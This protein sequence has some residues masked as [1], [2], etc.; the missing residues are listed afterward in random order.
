M[1]AAPALTLDGIETSVDRSQFGLFVLDVVVHIS[2]FL[3]PFENHT[4]PTHR[5]N[6]SSQLGQVSF[7]QVLALV[8]LERLHVLFG[9]LET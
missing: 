5:V 3:S 7:G 9:L 4:L 1:S 8:P 6:V 2:D